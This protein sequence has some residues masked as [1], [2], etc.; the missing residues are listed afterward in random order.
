M[1]ARQEPLGYIVAIRGESGLRLPSFPDV[2]RNLDEAAAERDRFTTLQP[3]PV[4]V[5]GLH[6]LTEE[7]G[8]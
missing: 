2:H 4:V 8:Q 3:D 6:E 7:T 5:L 1:T